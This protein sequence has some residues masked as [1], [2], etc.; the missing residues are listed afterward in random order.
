MNDA[1]HPEAPAP[2]DLSGSEFG[3]YRIIRRLGQGGMG[4]VYLA[5]QVS[6]K[7]KVALKFLKPELAAN[8]IA[9]KRF[10]S[11][12]EAVARLSHANIVQVYAVGEWGGRHFMALEYVDGRTLRELVVSKGPPEI[13]I[14][15]AIMRQVASALQKA[16]ESGLVHRD[17]KPENILI[18]RKVEVKVADFGLSRLFGEKADLNLT[19]TGMTLGTPLYMSPEQVR[20]ESLDPRSD[21]YSFGVTC[22][23]M[24]AGQ[25][26]FHGQTAIEVALKHCER[27]PPPLSSL[28]PDLPP[29]LCGFVHRLMHKDPEQRPQSGHE[30]L[31]E[32][33]QGFRPLPN[34]NP[35]E[36]L[37]LTATDLGKTRI[38]VALASAE[39]QPLATLKRALR[40]WLLVGATLVV[41][42]VIG[43]GAKLLHNAVAAPRIEINDKPDLDVVSNH[44]RLLLLAVEENANPK[45]DKMREAL[46]Y[47]V[48]L[49][50]LYWEQG[51]FDE[52]EHFFDEL[53]KRPNAPR[54]YTI[55]GYL[56]DA[57]TLSF[58]S[59][60]ES[61]A[62]ATKMFTDLRSRFPNYAAL[63][64][65]GMPIEESINLKYW[66][67]RAVDRLATSGGALPQALERIREDVKGKRPAGPP[68]KTN[69]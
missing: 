31:R 50:T 23:Y 29:E 41:A 27:D 16:G 33:T 25:P 67:V 14:C 36:D 12:A 7:R 18:T 34:A 3:D 44:E 58:R 48:R 60:S 30:I 52:A 22:Y 28:R 15:L 35:F 17:I 8:P 9:L 26:P 40:P 13:P 1:T 66:L 6:L 59:D 68:S 11:E 49:G 24:L 42:G 5:D 63:L 69:P 21:I 46:S 4:A 47:H 43:M 10:R 64:N 51:R 62:K 56:G 45:P 19:Q 37:S 57:I 54:Q 39:T 32:L 53:Q 61:A 2:G 65:S 20:G 38:S 55:L